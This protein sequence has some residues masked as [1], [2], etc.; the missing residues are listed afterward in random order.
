MGAEGSVLLLLH[1]DGHGRRFWATPG[2]GIEAG[3]SP[4]EAAQREALE[5]LG[6]TE[7]DLQELWT[8]QVEFEIADRSITQT[9]TFF[10]VRTCADVVRCE[11]NERLRAE[12]IEEFRWWKRDE[13]VDVDPPIFPSDLQSRLTAML[14]E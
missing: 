3:E 8:D 9:E 7:V 2:G 5:E 6:L 10:F 4:R 11:L 13:M 1:H 14:Q 12:G